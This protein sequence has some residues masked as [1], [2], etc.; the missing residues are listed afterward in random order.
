[1]SL[2]S[3]VFLGFLCLALL[4][5]YLV[6][7]GCQWWVLLAASTVFYLSHDLWAIF[8]LAL[9]VALTY[10]A[11]CWLGQLNRQES[12]ILEQTERGE[13]NGVKKAF[14][15]KKRGVLTTALCL[16]FFTLFLLKYLNWLLPGVNS[17]LGLLGPERTLSP[18]GLLLP[19]GISFYIFQTSGYLIDLYRGKLEP[20]KN[21]LRYALFA[22]YFPQMIQGPIHR[23]AQLGTQLR[24]EH[25]F[26]S[27]N[28]RD[29]I[30]LMMW[31]MLKKVL[32]ADVLVHGVNELY[33]NYGAYSG[34]LVFFGAALYCLQ[35][36]CDFSGGVDMVRGVSQMFGITLGEN[37][38]RPYFATSIE[39]F[40]QRWHISLGD[41]MKDYVFYPLALSKWLPKAC[42]KLRKVC[43]PRVGK[44]LVPSI[45]TVVVFLL[46]GIWQGPGL[47]NIAY[48][49]Y[50]GLLMS[51][52]ML[53]APLF[54]KLGG[55]R[56]GRGMQLFRI[57]RTCFLVT[58]G[59]FF[60][61][62]ESLSH[63]L[64]M[65]RHC[66]LH[67]FRGLCPGEFLSFGLT[68]GN[69]LTAGLFSLVLFFISYQQEKGTPIRKTLAGKKP[70]VQFLVLLGALLLLLTSVYLN[71]DYTPI[72]YVYE[73]V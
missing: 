10:G 2:S 27:E 25:P 67:P 13:R 51:G 6:P 3:T 60:S 63:A 52:A 1:M 48:G 33:G 41:W 16:N 72:A 30:Q 40:W 47:H 61:H 55:K 57:L 56:Q 50:N 36:Y 73:N 11:G 62:A 39:N 66:L 37:F 26:Q 31:G 21:F 22:S 45:S 8:Y 12:R 43:S 29:G 46:V 69:Y 32:I 15:K 54:V 7:K 19:L 44:L 24:Q 53:F 35:L 9:T 28:L 42:K 65:L 70:I 14:R 59:R 71:G 49:L 20:E 23:Y 4:A 17:L 38:R 68:A 64:G 5:Y 58:I 18:L 34:V